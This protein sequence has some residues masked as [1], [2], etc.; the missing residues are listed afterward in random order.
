M[1]GGWVEPSKTQRSRVGIS[2][3]QVERERKARK[4]EH[5][6]TAGMRYTLAIRTTLPAVSLDKRVRSFSD[7]T[8]SH[9]ETSRSTKKTSRVRRWTALNSNRPHTHMGGK[10]VSTLHVNIPS[11]SQIDLGEKKP[12]QLWSHTKSYT[13][14][15]RHIIWD[16][17]KQHDCAYAA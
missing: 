11:T 3:N 5:E 1:R 13:K 6:D 7:R 12:W 9:F 4:P 10:G 2:N 16:E 17:C 8:G 15:Q 14:T